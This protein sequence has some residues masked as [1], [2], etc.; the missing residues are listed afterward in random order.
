METR[1]KLKISEDKPVPQSSIPNI[2]GENPTISS[3]RPKPPLPVTPPPKLAK[4]AT[5]PNPKETPPKMPAVG[6][7]NQ[8][9][10]DRNSPVKSDKTSSAKRNFPDKD[11]E[12]K[13]L[14]KKKQY[15]T[16]HNITAGKIALF[17][18]GSKTV[19]PA[20]EDRSH[21]LYTAGLNTGEAIAWVVDRYKAAK[22]AYTRGGISSLT[23]NPELMARAKV[24]FILKTRAALDASGEWGFTVRNRKGDEYI[25]SWQFLIRLPEKDEKIETADRQ[26]WGKQLAVFFGNAEVKEHKE[27]SMDFSPSPSF[28]GQLPPNCF[29]YAGESN[30]NG[31]AALLAGNIFKKVDV[32]MNI[33][34]P[35]FGRTPAEVC[36]EDWLLGAY[37]G[38][39]LAEEVK[40]MYLPPPTYATP[41]RDEDESAEDP[42]SDLMAA[43][44]S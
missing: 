23:N 44:E 3:D 37:F 11:E 29:T 7:P 30:P 38:L 13:F 18:N 24:S 25:L 10:H 17:G 15:L 20:T 22:P 34:L 14:N 36:A 1:H 32:M 39:G 42:D 5:T 9:V 4:V 40:L 6:L 31:D 41:I 19:S 35:Q 27:K 33:I 43:F 16:K 2:A 8:L 12:E 21:K 28:A 26:K